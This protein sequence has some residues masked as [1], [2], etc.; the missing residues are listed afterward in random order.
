M[1]QGLLCFQHIKNNDYW[2]KGFLFSTNK[3]PGRI[4]AMIIMFSTTEIPGSIGAKI[5]MFSRNEIAVRISQGL[6][7]FQQ[8]K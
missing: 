2:R 1:P 3:L 7:C 5:V 8:M 4:G 6:L